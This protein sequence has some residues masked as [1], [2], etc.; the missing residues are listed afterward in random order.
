MSNAC[1]YRMEQ[2][3]R[4]RFNRP[5]C[6]YKAFQFATTLL[7]RHPLQDTREGEKCKMPEVR[8]TAIT[9]NRI[10]FFYFELYLTVRFG[11]GWREKGENKKLPE[12]IPL[13]FG[14]VAFARCE[15]VGGWWT[16]ERLGGRVGHKMQGR[17]SA[18][19][20]RVIVFLFSDG[21]KK[22]YGDSFSAL[23]YYI[24]ISK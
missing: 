20:E 4:D 21:K 13:I 1:S 23:F 24:I 14:Q 10:F 9:S 8:R 15:K 22:Q 5:A 18:F 16:G 17:H 6:R 12:H 3:L 11:K 2:Y 19:Q 7:P